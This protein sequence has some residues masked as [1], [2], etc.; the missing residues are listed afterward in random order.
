MRFG[1]LVMKIGVGASAVTDAAD[2][3]LQPIA[4]A[5]QVVGR[6]APLLAS[7]E[8]AAAR[9]AP[10]AVVVR[11]GWAISAS[12]KRE[13]ARLS[14]G[15]RRAMRSGRNS[16]GVEMALNVTVWAGS[17]LVHSQNPGVGGR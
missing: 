11:L 10:P 12:P 3:R 14:G 7:G 16:R 1:F 4:H 8:A 9:P 5:F 17:I 6:V 13:K 2:Q 15:E